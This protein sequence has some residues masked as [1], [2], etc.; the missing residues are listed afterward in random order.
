MKF[1]SL[2]AGCMLAGITL[3]G[4]SA[5]VRAADEACADPNA[6]APATGAAQ[7]CGRTRMVGSDKISVFQGIPYAT[8]DRFKPSGLNPLPAEVPFTASG[9]GVVCP[10]M[11]S[12]QDSGET[13]KAFIG[14]D[15]CLTLNV[16]APQGA[17]PG[18]YPVMV[19]IYGGA[20][21]IGSSM[22]GAY[23]AGQNG[24][25]S[26]DPD[27]SLYDG[28]ILASGRPTG[29]STQKAV[30]VTF[31]YR[32]GAL[33]F[34]AYSFAGD[35][36][37]RGNQGISDQVNA[38]RWVLEN[39][40][41][42]GGNPQN[43]TLFGESAGAMSAG[44]LAYT[45]TTVNEKISGLIMESNPMGILYEKLPH[46]GTG[47]AHYQENAAMFVGEL[48][49]IY[50][51]QIGERPEQCPDDPLN[52]DWMSAVEDGE[53]CVTPEMVVDAQE[54]V[55]A[56][57]IGEIADKKFDLS[58]VLPWLPVIDTGD[59]SMY[60]LGGQTLDGYA[61]GVSK[62]I[63]TMYGTNR[64]EGVLFLNALVDH[65]VLANLTDEAYDSLLG[66][67]FPNLSVDAI[68]TQMTTEQFDPTTD[69]PYCAGAASNPP[70]TRTQAG[71]LKDISDPNNPLPSPPL[72]ALANAATDA[73]FRCAN[74]V[75]AQNAGTRDG[76]VLYPYIFSSAP[77]TAVF[78][79]PGPAGEADTASPCDSAEPFSDMDDQRPS[80]HGAELSFVFDTITTVAHMGTIGSAGTDADTLA[81][82]TRMA[83][84]WLTF[85]QDPPAFTANGQ[86][87]SKNKTGLQPLTVY[88]TGTET[89]LPWKGYVPGDGLSDMLTAYNCDTLWK[90][91]AF[92]VGG[93]SA[94][95]K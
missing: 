49:S 75:F 78:G 81:L 48:W 69:T 53:Y 51:K 43:I 13:K 50:H 10:Q 45:N 1:L 70:C 74:Q 54:S 89:Q 64:D 62:A 28:S 30:V 88:T 63:P 57:L 55:T 41:V 36:V 93:T 46:D 86:P 73:V 25:E 3:M 47:V 71:Y 37:F 40:E 31:N 39:I 17:E 32:L 6:V 8:A 34:L 35:M 84:D 56:T 33:G 58:N 95:M 26:I 15:D 11:A 23:Q 18:Q 79:V 59:S 4:A 9:F 5:D 21:V 92:A 22:D 2:V 12:Y 80:C 60:T 7:W 90:A 16:Y 77:A 94:A 20:F 82:A 85:A 24:I 91:D 27:G 68:K 66:S 19:F 42:F 72:T 83:G 14:D 67:L 65:G 52:I 61:P 87:M 38:V 76:Q 29:D 44:L